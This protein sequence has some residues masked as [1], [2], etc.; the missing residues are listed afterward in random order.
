MDTPKK[1]IV[2]L[3]DLVGKEI[4]RTC[5]TIHFFGFHPLRFAMNPVILKSVNAS[6]QFDVVDC[7]ALYCTSHLP[8]SAD[9]GFWAEWKT[10]TSA[11]PEEF[12][13]TPMHAFIGKKIKRD[14]S[15]PELPDSYTNSI[16]SG[17]ILKDIMISGHLIISL[18][19]PSVTAILFPDV[20]DGKW[21]E[22]EGDTFIPGPHILAC[23]ENSLVPNLLELN[24]SG[25]S[26]TSLPDLTKTHTAEEKKEPENS[27]ATC[28]ICLDNEVNHIVIPCGHCC[29]CEGCSDIKAL[30]SKCPICRKEILIIT[31][32]YFS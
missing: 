15:I 26:L 6:G 27:S 18:F 17:V 22:C 10:S 29:L 9:D 21:I 31:K 8:P 1:N 24:C 23:P 12:K 16:S 19:T 30:K 7:D 2:S 25:C 3:K 14:A 32:M 13:R 4:I 5:K 20:N 11:K 28:V